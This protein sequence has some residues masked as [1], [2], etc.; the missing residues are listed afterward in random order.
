M[1]YTVCVKMLKALY[2]PNMVWSPLPHTT[3]VFHVIFSYDATKTHTT[4]SDSYQ[5]LKFALF[6]WEL[7][8]HWILPD[9][10]QL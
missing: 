6:I 3:D 10:L 4:E 2:F 1:L 7:Q 9:K 8:Q 5:I